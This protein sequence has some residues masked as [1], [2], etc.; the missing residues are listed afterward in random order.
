MVT[1]L[2]RFIFFLLLAYIIYLFVRI[3]FSLKRA[4]KRTGPP[5][6][7]QGEMVK[8][9][10]CNTYVPKEEA[11]R[12]ALDGREHFFCSEACRKKFLSR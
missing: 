1:G 4:R 9:E 12:E 7:I 3:Y 10:M 11:L 8:D 6:R 5:R 2:F